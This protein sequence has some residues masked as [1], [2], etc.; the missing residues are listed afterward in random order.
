MDEDL[1]FVA[2]G[3]AARRG[4]LRQLRRGA[5]G[6]VKELKQRWKRVNDQLRQF[7][8]PALQAVTAQRDIGLLGLLVILL[9][10]P[11]VS[12]PHG[13]V[14]GLPAVGFAPHYGVF[15]QQD[16]RGIT[17]EEVL[18]GAGENNRLVLAS[19]RPG[20]D[21][22]FLLEQSQKDADRGFCTAPM[23]LSELQRELKGQEFRLIPRCVITQ[24]SGKQRVIDNADTG[25]QSLRSSDANKLVLCSPLRP[26]QHIAAVMQRM[27]E[28]QLRSAREGDSWES[29]GE[30]WPDAYR[31]SPMS[32]EEARGC[33]VCF[34]HEGWGAPAFQRFA[35]LLFGLP[36]A[37]TSF[38]RY[39]RLAEAL[40][41]RLLVLL[42]SFYFDDAHITDWR[43]AGGSGQWA[44]EE[45]N[46]LLG[47]PFSEDKK[48]P[49]AAQG[50]FLGLDHD[51]S[52]AL[53]NGV[54]SS[55]LGSGCTRRCS[56]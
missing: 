42:V 20:K 7:Q 32:S 10:W 44:L 47:T 15:P 6:A 11:D 37:V 17:F 12:Y 31:H 25:G 54:V 14:V 30:D 56:G 34:W 53:R 36:L 28:R 29:G 38:N 13:L 9:A 43:S 2:T 23:S 35:G 5:I 50:L 49:M 33:I 22:T 16:A 19:L 1:Q 40:A 55:G 21:D 52:H 45:L 26:A 39:S 51:L 27:D 8:A 3:M 24:S 4:D 18:E 48:Q 41:R 46:R